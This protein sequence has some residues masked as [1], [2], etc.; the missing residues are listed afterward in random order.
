MASGA[1]PVLAIVTP[2]E[3]LEVPSGWVG[4]VTFAGVTVAAGIPGLLPVSNIGCGEPE[5]LSRITTDPVRTPPAVGVNVIET[6]QLPAAATLDPQLLVSAKSPSA[7][8][9][10]IESDEFPILRTIVVCGGLVWPRAATENCIES[11]LMDTPGP[12]P[13]AIFKINA[14]YESTRDPWKAPGVTGKSVEVVMP[15]R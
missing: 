11:G 12:V 10:K 6:V 2:W 8:I 7:T 9:D 5:A 3:L 1:L 13:G 15:A 4:N 14:S